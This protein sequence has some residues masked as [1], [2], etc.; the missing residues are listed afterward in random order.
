MRTGEDVTR[1]MG[2]MKGAVMKF[3]QILSLMSGVVPDEMSAQLAS[4]QSNAPPMSYHLVEE[5]FERE[6]GLPPSKVFRHFEHAPFAAASIGQVHRATLHDG[7]RVAVKVQYPGVREAIGH[8]LANVG[9]MISIA[10]VLS[11]GLDAGPIVRDLKEGHPGRAR[12]PARGGV[13]ATLLQRIRGPRIHPHPARLSRSDDVA[14]A[15]AGVHR[16]QAVRG[17]G[18]AGRGRAKPY[19][20]DH[21]SLRL[22]LDLPAQPVQRRPASR[23]LPA[24]A[25][26]RRRV[27]R[28]RLRRRVL[29]TRRSLASCG[30]CAR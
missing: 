23:Q 3:G 17:G 10:G 13:A 22:R 15:R 19:R 21:L 6:F 30:S 29:R 26:R 4:L 25:R 7:T 11:R 8:D 20:R 14:R 27:R 24:A 28:L 9:M 5:V 1:T 16:G 2:D 12:L 18:G